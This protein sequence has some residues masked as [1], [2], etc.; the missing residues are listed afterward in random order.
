MIMEILLKVFLFIWKEIFWIFCG[1]IVGMY[2]NLLGGGDPDCP[3]EAV[4]FSGPSQAILSGLC[5][6]YASFYD[7]KE[8]VIIMITANLIIGFF[9]FYITRLINN[10]FKKKRK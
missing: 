8:R 10:D 1:F 4:F 7:F 3:I 9:I 6:F 5:C 2:A